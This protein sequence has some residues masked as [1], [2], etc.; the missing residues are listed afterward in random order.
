MG[1]AGMGFCQNRRYRGVRYVLGGGGIEGREV[2]RT[3]GREREAGEEGREE[4]EDRHS[5]KYISCTNSK[6]NLG[7]LFANHKNFSA[8]LTNTPNLLGIFPRR[9]CEKN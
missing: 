2:S 3:G 9:R 4:G 5:N 8:R 7:I 1:F 6:E